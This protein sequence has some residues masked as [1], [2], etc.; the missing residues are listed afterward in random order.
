MVY[1]TRSAVYATTKE[2]DKDC[3]GLAPMV[4]KKGRVFNQR[5]SAHWLLWICSGLS[6]AETVA[7][8]GG[9]SEPT[10][11]PA[12]TRALDSTTTATRIAFPAKQLTSRASAAQIWVANFC[13]QYFSNSG[14]PA[15]CLH[16]RSVHSSFPVDHIT[17][18][19]TWLRSWPAAGASRF[20][21]TRRPFLFN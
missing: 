14:E 12:E 19:R 18:K 3:I 16:H 6:T 1:S 21:T 15:S 17:R 8:P 4:E 9:F 13:A 7:Q 2:L 20:F 10:R 11:S 5:R